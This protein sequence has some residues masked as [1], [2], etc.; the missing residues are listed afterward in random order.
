MTEFFNEICT[1]HQFIIFLKSH[2]HIKAKPSTS[3]TPSSTTLMTTTTTS[4]RTTA[5]T[6]TTKTTTTTTTTT[7]TVALPYDQLTDTF[8]RYLN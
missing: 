6:T 8:D 3:A 7:T 2:D 1:F 5:K 4:A